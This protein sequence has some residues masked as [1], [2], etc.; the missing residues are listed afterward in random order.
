MM[1]ASRAS[2]S[3]DRCALRHVLGAAGGRDPSLIAAQSYS[4]TMPHALDELHLRGI[5]I[6]PDNAPTDVRSLQHHGFDVII[7]PG[8]GHFMFLEDPS[9]FNGLLRHAIGKLTRD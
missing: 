2:A 5:A 7:M 8:V 6:N 4:L 9:R 3:G 1:T